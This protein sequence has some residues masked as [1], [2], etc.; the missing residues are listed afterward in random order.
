LRRQRR[1][2]NAWRFCAPVID[3]GFYVSDVDGCHGLRMIALKR[4]Q[5][6]APGQVPF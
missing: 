2:V 5:P 3:G 1:A 4:I 6:V